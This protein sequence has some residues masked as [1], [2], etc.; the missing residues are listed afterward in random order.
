PIS[1]TQV[2]HYNKLEQK[3]VAAAASKDS[4]TNASSSHRETYSG[5]SNGSKK[6]RPS[7]TSETRV[8]AAVVLI[9]G[10]LGLAI[11]AKDD[12]AP[13][14][15]SGPRRKSLLAQLVDATG[16]TNQPASSTPSSASES[17]PNNT[18]STRA[19]GGY[20]TKLEELRSQNRV[21]PLQ[22]NE[23]ALSAEHL[24]LGVFG[25]V[26]IDTL[27][28]LRRAQIQLSPS[29]TGSPATAFEIQKTSAGELLVVGYV[30]ESDFERATTGRPM[31][32]ALAPKTGRRG[33]LISI[34]MDRIKTVTLKNEQGERIAELSLG[35]AV[36]NR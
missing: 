12:P 11:S 29:S 4:T 16:E 17:A 24:P 27:P 34:P 28:R 31:R 20:A 22:D 23:A 6:A 19:V 30:W 2:G 26:G 35:S 10:G 36:S 8:A 3:L 9:V 18:Q 13:S 21:R 25:F 1:T 14:G 33:R 15:D 7:S 5:R 32:I